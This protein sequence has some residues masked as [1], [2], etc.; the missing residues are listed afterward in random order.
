[1]QQQTVP[2]SVI[3]PLGII[4]PQWSIII[5][6]NEHES[7]KKKK[8]LSHIQKCLF[9]HQEKVKHYFY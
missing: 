5:D 9:R 8:T 7:L 2:L 6:H 1:M 3:V 4:R